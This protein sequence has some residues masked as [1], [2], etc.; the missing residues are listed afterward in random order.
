MD[1]WRTRLRQF[2]KSRQLNSNVTDDS[3]S[4]NDL[5]K[6]SNN[7]WTWI[8]GNE[9]ANVV[10]VY[11]SQSVPDPGNVPGSRSDAALWI[12]NTGNIWIFGGLGSG[13]NQQ[14]QSD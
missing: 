10:G 5:W 9:N 12:D 13:V 7:T 1:I 2:G 4:L 6:Y 11:G 8:T 14:G 3:G